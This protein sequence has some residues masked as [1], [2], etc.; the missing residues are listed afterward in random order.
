MISIELSEWKRRLQANEV[1]NEDFKE[2]VEVPQ[3]L[4]QFRVRPG[5]GVLQGFQQ[6]GFVDGVVFE[7]MRWEGWPETKIFGN[8]PGGFGG[9]TEQRWR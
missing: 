4:V 3:S 6:A 9:G 1:I 5:G 2:V 7:W 8:V